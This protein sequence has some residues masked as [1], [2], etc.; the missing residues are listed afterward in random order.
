MK[1]HDGKTEDNIVNKGVLD[2]KTEDN[3]VTKGPQL[4]FTHEQL[5]ELNKKIELGRCVKLIVDK[6]GYNV[7]GLENELKEALK[8]YELHGESK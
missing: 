7:N 1:K 2:G 6:H 3:I 5:E 8:N 4:N